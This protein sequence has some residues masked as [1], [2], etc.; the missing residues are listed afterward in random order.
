VAALINRLMLLGA[1]CIAAA[2]LVPIF[3]SG[4]QLDRA[5]GALALAGPAAA[6]AVSAAVGRPNLAAAALA[7]VGAYATGLLT[8]AG[9]AVPVAILCATAVA[10]AAGALIAVL[11]A[12]MEATA[13][14]VASLLLALGLGALVQ[15]LPMQTGAESGLGPLPAIQ[16]PAGSSHNAVA[17]P[18]GDFHFL[19]AAAGA[20]MAGAAAA[21]RFG[22]GPAWR[23]IGSD[24]SRAAASGISPLAGQVTALAFGGLLAGLSGAFA[25]HVSRLASPSSFSVDA[26]ALPLL[27]AL[28]AGRQPLEAGVIAV[29]TGIVGQVILPAA[30]WHGPPDATSLALGLLAVATVATLLPSRAEGE[31]PSRAEATPATPAWPTGG[32]GLAGSRLV[33][34]AIAVRSPEGVQLL[35]A[36]AFTVEPGELRGIVGPNGSGKTTLL[37]TLAQRAGRSEDVLLSD[38]PAPRCLLMP[39]EGGGWASCTVR[40]TLVLAATLGRP[41]EVAT[42][43]ASDWMDALGL[44]DVADAYCAELAAGRR[45]LVELGRVLLSRPSVL[46]CDEPL[47]GL[48]DSLRTT[49]RSCLRAAADAG[50]TVVLAEHDRDAVAEMADRVLTLARADTDSAPAS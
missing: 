27:A 11:G 31:P 20:S 48:D 39:Q 28:A 8:Q 49:A 4:P 18:I 34:R 22:T 26:A 9:V 35:A 30:G 5:A 40:E 23:A 2:L 21:L 12:R 32:L 14:L 7:G 19:L 17:T 37:R 44:T 33:A 36:P 41:R 46:L 38:G 13:F 45:R 24:R 1:A 29:L 50:L 42:H 15:A 3:A 10:T 25:A 6:A 43:L 16:F 47:A